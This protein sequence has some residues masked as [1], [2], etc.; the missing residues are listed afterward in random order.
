MKWVD[1]EKSIARHFRMKYGSI[2][3]KLWMN[4]LPIIEGD[5]AIDLQEFADRAAEVLEAIGY[6]QPSKYAL[7]KP[8]NSNT[9]PIRN[10]T[11]L[12]SNFS[13]R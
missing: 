3:E 1:F 7:Y 9:S 11:Q 6:G 5:K 8:K 13:T 2:G 12:M 4:E 10:I